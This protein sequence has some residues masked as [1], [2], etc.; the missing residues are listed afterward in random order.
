MSKL[1]WKCFDVHLG[2]VHVVIGVPFF[3]RGLMI[4]YMN[5]RGDDRAFQLVVFHNDTIV[6]LFALGEWRVVV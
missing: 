1:L 5:K 2:R 3:G 4:F 6:S